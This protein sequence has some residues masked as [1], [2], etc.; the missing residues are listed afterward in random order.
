MQLRVIYLSLL[1]TNMSLALRST[2]CVL[3][4]VFSFSRTSSNVLPL[5]H[6]LTLPNLDFESL[7]TAVVIVV[8]ECN[9]QLPLPPSNDVTVFDVSNLCD[10]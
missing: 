1:P 2:H 4:Y 3:L 5:P 8:V 9:F 7:I 6:R 10:A